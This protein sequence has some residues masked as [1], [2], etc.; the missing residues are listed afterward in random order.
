MPQFNSFHMWISTR[1]QREI[2]TKIY[3][4]EV[5][6]IRPKSTNLKDLDF[7]QHI[8][9]D[10]LLSQSPI[11]CRSNTHIQTKDRAN[12]EKI[13][14]LLLHNSLQQCKSGTDFAMIIDKWLELLLTYWELLTG[15]IPIT[16]PFHPSRSVLIWTASLWSLSPESAVKEHYPIIRSL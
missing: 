11:T 14:T 10:W 5:W 13:H 1:I 8:R 6:P 9:R 3:G 4:H 15:K 2:L 12:S 16:S 7:C